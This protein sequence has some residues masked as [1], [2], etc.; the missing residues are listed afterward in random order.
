MELTQRP[1]SS[2]SD[3][4]GWRCSNQRCANRCSFRT[5]RTGSF[6]EKSKI[7]LDKWLYVIY[8]W[9]QGTKVTTASKM[10]Q[11]SEKS[12]IQMFQY[13]RE[14]CS[15][16]LIQTPAQLGG[17]GVIVQID[18]SLF[19]HKPKYNRGRRARAHEEVWVFGHIVSNH[20]T[21]CKTGFNSVL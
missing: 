6:F 21:H 1:T 12:T 2:T 18:E 19:N 9:S 16:K 5:I 13:L 11:V 20:T 8:F 14:V 7:T 4:W 10:V 17:P 15:T 3:G